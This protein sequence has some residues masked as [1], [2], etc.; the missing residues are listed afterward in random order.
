MGTGGVHGHCFS[1]L[2]GRCFLRDA[3]CRGALRLEHLHGADRHRPARACGASRPG[4]SARST[5]TSERSVA[6]LPPSRFLTAFSAMPARSA[7]CCWLR[8]CRSLERANL[9]AEF[10]LPTRLRLA[11]QQLI[12]LNRYIVN[13]YIAYIP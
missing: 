5:C 8:F 9:P 12:D 2:D 1:R 6:P 4:S 7:S 10:S 13:L 3:R 11:Q